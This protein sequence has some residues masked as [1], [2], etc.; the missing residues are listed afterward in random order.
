MWAIR[1]TA[2][3]QPAQLVEVAEPEPRPGEV[4]VKVAGAGLCHSDLHL[5][6]MA[7]AV[8]EPFTLGHETAGWVEAVGP[9]AEAPAVGDAGL[10]HGAWG[11]GGGARGRAGGG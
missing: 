10:V 9:G 3:Q 8:E 1:L 5:M 4:L 2:W 11:C 6:H 7:A